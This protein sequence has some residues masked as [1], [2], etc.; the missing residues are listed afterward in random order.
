MELGDTQSC[1]TP[2]LERLQTLLF[3]AEKEVD[4]ARRSRI[5]A[6]RLLGFLEAQTTSYEDEAYLDSLREQACSQLQKARDKHISL[7][8][9]SILESAGVPDTFGFGVNGALDL[10]SLRECEPFGTILSNAE[11]LQNKRN[12]QSKATSSSALIQKVPPPQSVPQIFQAPTVPDRTTYRQSKLP[13]LYTPSANRQTSYSAQKAASVK[14]ES[15]ASQ[16]RVQ[17]LS[18]YAGFSKQKTQPLWSRGA[19]KVGDNDDD[20]EMEFDNAARRK[21]SELQEDLSPVEAHRSK[22]SKRRL[23]DEDDEIEEVGPTDFMSAKQKLVIENAKKGLHS[24]NVNPPQ[25]G[26]KPPAMK[27]GVRGAF[28]PPIKSG[29]TAPRKPD[30]GAEQGGD[31]ESEATRKLLESLAGPDG[32]LPDRIKNIEP[33]LLEHISNEIIDKAP[34]VTWGDIAGLG[35]AKKSIQELVVWPLKRPDLFAGVRSPGKGLLLFGPPGTG[36]TLLG[37]AIAAEANATFF[38]I[39][40]SSLTSKWI[41]EG[42]KLVRALFGVAG[43]RQPAVIFIDEVDSLLSQR[44]SDG[45]HESSRRLK[46]EF[47]VQMEGCCGGDERVLLIGATNRPQEL[48]EAARRRLSK[49]LYIPL[50]TA[51]ARAAIVQNLLQKDGL[52]NLSDSDMDSIRAK[53]KGY[54]GS[55]VKNLVK[56][57]SLGPL[58]EAAMMHGN[59]D[60][61]TRD[62]MRPITLSDFENALH[63]VRA[64]VS[65]DELLAYQDWNKQFGSLAVGEDEAE[66]D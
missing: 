11:I 33:R 53:T 61:V 8:A 50:P 42:E 29:G 35:H 26:F 66:I 52:M 12:R 16:P 63:Q 55:D 39:S 25:Q 20:D 65:P 58:R 10:S 1:D 51:G 32:E 34:N 4:N 17:I 13:S 38:S 37:K 21:R 54:S 46:T 14:A 59:I 2:K 47:L 64:S 15:D 28:I 23:S 9:R 60:T 45:E 22:Q 41:G 6:T 57:A 30:K 7:D 43:C 49:R 3:S 5:I 48:D 44:K 27:R 31:E 62:Q 56:E 24:R 18:S 36:K 40:A 19:N